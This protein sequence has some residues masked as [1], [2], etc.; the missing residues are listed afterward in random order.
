MSVSVRASSESAELFV[1][2]RI[3]RQ[4]IEI[5][6][7][8]RSPTTVIVGFRRGDLNFLLDGSDLG[9]ME[10][11]FGNGPRFSDH[12][13]YINPDSKEGVS[14]LLRFVAIDPATYLSLARRLK[15]GTIRVSSGNEA[16]VETTFTLPNGSGDIQIDSYADFEEDLSHFSK[17]QRLIFEKLMCRQAVLTLQGEEGFLARDVITVA[18]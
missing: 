6:R 11:S 2:I 13:V 18:G 9:D 16:E 3:E 17:E 5:P 12:R 1:E 15:I 10:S 8:G 4:A 14:H 7:P